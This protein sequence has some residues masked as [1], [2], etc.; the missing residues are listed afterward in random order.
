[1]I[2]MI[3]IPCLHPNHH[4]DEKLCAATCQ[5]EIKLHLYWMYAYWVWASIQSQEL[6]K[7]GWSTYRYLQRQLRKSD[8]KSVACRPEALL[9][10]QLYWI[11]LSS[12]SEPSWEE[13]P[14]FE[15]K[16]NSIMDLYNTPNFNWL[17]CMILWLWCL[18][19]LQ[20]PPL[21]VGHLL[22]FSSGLIY[23][24]PTLVPLGMPYFQFLIY[25]S[26]VG[27]TAG[28][29]SVLQPA[30]SKN[31]VALIYHNLISTYITN[32]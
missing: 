2:S 13:D 22:R 20:L 25:Y 29:M 7:E 9:Y 4:L 27:R 16:F 26:E 1:M 5:D 3:P 11:F 28:K 8:Q 23:W 24:Y 10:W 15:E 21:V 14:E 12:S 6:H 17:L 31:D 30:T 32:I 18:K 19:L